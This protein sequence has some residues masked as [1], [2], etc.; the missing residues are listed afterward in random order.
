MPSLR[1]SCLR[2]LCFALACTCPGGLAAALFLLG[3]LSQLAFISAQQHKH[4]VQD[5][6][7]SAPSEPMMGAPKGVFMRPLL[8]V[9]YDEECR[10]VECLV[11]SLC[12]AHACRFGRRKHWADKSEKLGSAF[13]VEALIAQG[14]NELLLAKA[15]T[16]HNTLFPP[17]VP[18]QGT[19]NVQVPVVVT[20]FEGDAFARWL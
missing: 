9:L 12:H 18:Q 16:V 7:L 5:I 3:F 10:C 19:S 11:A 2:Y 8:G 13:S 1:R 4:H 15:R 20:L 14:R 6:M 17:A